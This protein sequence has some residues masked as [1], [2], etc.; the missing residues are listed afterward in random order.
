MNKITPSML[1]P[2]VAPEWML[3]APQW[4]E[5]IFFNIFVCINQINELS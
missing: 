2:E 5:D 4:L 3:N 1:W